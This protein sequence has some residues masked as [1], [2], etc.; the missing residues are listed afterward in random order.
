ML[1]GIRT[2]KSQQGEGGSKRAIT[3]GG[4][5]VSLGCCVRRHHALR[6]IEGESGK[7]RSQYK[8]ILV[9]GGG[10]KGA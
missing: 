9:R 3:F 2:R 5:T 6:A 4:R 7:G 10:S 8:K 1:L